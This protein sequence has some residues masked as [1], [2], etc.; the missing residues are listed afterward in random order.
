MKQCSNSHQEYF[1]TRF[2]Y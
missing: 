1:W 2:R